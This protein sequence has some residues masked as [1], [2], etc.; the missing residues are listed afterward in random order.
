MPMIS[1][2]SLLAVPTML[3]MP[4]VARAAA[5]V[6]ARIGVLNDEQSPM[7]IAWSRFGQL[8]RRRTD[9]A[10]DVQVFPNAQL[11]GEK[12]VA[13][14]IRLG[15]VQGAAITL[16]VLSAW[17]PEGQI[18][19]LPFLFRDLDHAHHVAAGPIGQALGAKYRPFGFVVL[20][21]VNIGTRHPLGKFP[22]ERPGDVK[23]KRIR[24]IQSPLHIALWR[25]LG[26][27][28]TPLPV[29]E[30]Y[31]AL[32]TGV[33]DFMD[34]SKTG[35]RQLRFYEVAPYFTELGHIY[36][37]GA[38]V[39]GAPFWNRLTPAQQA[40]VQETAREAAALHEHLEDYGGDVA[41][42]AVVKTGGVKVTRPDPAP[43]R[44]AMLPV[45][46]EFAPKLGGMELVH[47]IQQ[48]A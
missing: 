10:I 37:L 29:T 27:I 24:V 31:N 47:Q 8:L 9:G 18:F 23:G 32:E 45:W 42:A 11:G 30:A 14:G 19:E 3:A 36:S 33:V 17:V 13:D 7:F 39:V 43:W 22:I 41:L 20:D 6:T 34:M 15:S 35:Y 2:R 26:A 25:E 12:D 44:Q 1:R 40:I 46:Q 5:P 38:F 4:F 16:A 48:T 28:P 21:Y